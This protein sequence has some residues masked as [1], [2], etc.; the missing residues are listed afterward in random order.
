MGLT[1]FFKNKG[2]LLFDGLVDFHNHVLPGIDDGSK[3]TEESLKMIDG[4]EKLGVKKLIPSPHIYHGLYPNTPQIIEK[5]YEALCGREK[6]NSHSVAF[7]GFAA[8]YM[9]DEF[10]LSSIQDGVP[11]LSCFDRHVLIEILFLDQLNILHEVLFLLQSQG[12]QPILAHPERYLKIKKIETLIDLKAKGAMLQ[13][14]GLSLTGH[15]G[16]SVKKK[17]IAWLRED[18]YDFVCTDAHNEEQLNQLAEL[19]LGKKEMKAWSAICDFQKD[20]IQV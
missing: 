10:F 12:Y 17:G 5:A 14:N 19:S 20:Y 7:K 16:Q 1:F 3:N 15:Y 8:E 2:S 18:I 4:F 9:V 11:L 13:L 6:Y